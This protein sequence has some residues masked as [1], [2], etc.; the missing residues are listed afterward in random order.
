V[1]ENSKTLVQCDFDGTVTEGDVSFLILDAFGS[2]GWRPLFRDYEEGR[3]TVGHFNAEAFSTVKA[4]KKSLLEIIRKETRL[5]P[6]FSELV[7]CC[8]RKGFR[9]VIV[10]NGLRFYIDD[11]LRSIGMSDLEVYAA[12]TCF[13]PDGLKVQYFGPDGANLDSDF[14]LA[15][16]DFF[17][18]QGYRLIYIGNGASDVSPARKSHYIFATDGLL[19]SCEK[20]DLTCTPFA[21]LHQIASVIE[22][23]E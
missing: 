1:A 15:Y 18:N 8:R 23:W 7:A 21:D 9:F 14:K 4:D 2:A 3:I 17:F 5:R 16:T 22:S 11:I 19:Q 13:Y 6:G 20:L 10:S 12:E